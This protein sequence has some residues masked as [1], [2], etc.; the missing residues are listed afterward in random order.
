MLI[1]CVD[2]P[3]RGKCGSASP[4]CSDSHDDLLSGML[5]SGGAPGAWLSMLNDAS[6]LSDSSTMASGD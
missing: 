1:V 6:T 5:T 4:R 3:T 2:V